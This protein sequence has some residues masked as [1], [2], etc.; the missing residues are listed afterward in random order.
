MSSSNFD[1]APKGLKEL[2]LKHAGK[3]GKKNSM[4]KGELKALLHE[5]FPGLLEVGLFL[6]LFPSLPLYLLLF[7]FYFKASFEDKKFAVRCHPCSSRAS[8]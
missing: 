3:S 5:L 6:R 8:H 7:V 2:F 1:L 4:N